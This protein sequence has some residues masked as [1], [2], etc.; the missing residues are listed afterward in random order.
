MWGLDFAMYYFNSGDL[1]IGL[2][3]ESPCGWGYF[4]W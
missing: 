1:C 2:W 4:C 3:L